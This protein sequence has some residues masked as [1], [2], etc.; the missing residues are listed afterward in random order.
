MCAAGAHD[1]PFGDGRPATQ[2]TEP[3]AAR[4]RADR[5]RS[6]SGG[7][8]RGRLQL[9]RSQHRRHPLLAARLPGRPARRGGR[10][11][12]QPEP[13]L[14][15][16]AADSAAL[17]RAHDRT[18]A[19][20]RGPADRLRRRLRPGHRRTRRR[21][22][23][24]SGQP[25]PPGRI[26]HLA[27]LAQGQTQVLGGNASVAGMGDRVAASDLPADGDG[28]LRHTLAQVNGLPTIAAVVSRELAA[29]PGHGGGSWKEAGSTSA[30]RPG[31]VKNLSFTDVLERAFRPGRGARARSSWSEPPPRAPG[32]ARHR[33]GQPHVRARSAGQRDRDCARGLA[34]AQC[35]RGGRAAADRGAR[36]AGVRRRRCAWTR[37][38]S[39]SPASE[40]WS[41]TPSPRS[42]PSTRRGARVRGP[43]DGAGGRHRRQRDPGHVVRQARAPA[44]TGAVRR[45]RTA[46]RGTGAASARP[47]PPR[48]D[49]DH[50][51]LSDRG[52]RSPAAEWGSST[53]PPSW[54]WTVRWRSS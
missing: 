4:G 7:A 28:V 14:P 21:S 26:R 6:G 3:R 33:R 20:G 2:R 45:Q 15:P 16:P 10:R 5:R 8:F 1:Y 54:R 17:P 41:A 40:R 23:A 35:V 9:A 44:A 48:P 13:A 43:G 18:P 42:S 27:D 32:R 37:S 29:P 19:R 30:G 12:R 53:A 49:R 52:A 39:A 38:G 25:G 47:A 36:G 51:R 31:T 50:R 24:R 11:D 34:P 22:P 46:G